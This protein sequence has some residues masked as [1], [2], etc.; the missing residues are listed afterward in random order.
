MIDLVRISEMPRAPPAPLFPGACCA[1][2]S[3][4]QYKLKDG[5]EREI[6][7]Q[8]GVI[9]KVL[10]TPRADEMAWASGAGRAQVLGVLPGQIW[11]SASPSSRVDRLRASLKKAAPNAKPAEIDVI[12]QLTVMDPNRRASAATALKL[13]YFAG[14]PAKQKPVVTKVESAAHIGERFAFERQREVHTS[15]DAL[16]R[17]VAGDVEKLSS[18]VPAA[19]DAGEAA[20]GD[21][22]LPPPAA[23]G[24]VVASLKEGPAAHPQQPKE[25]QSGHSPP[26]PKHGKTGHGKSGV[27]SGGGGGGP[28]AFG[29]T[30]AVLRAMEC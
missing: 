14:L 11:S 6:D 8:L 18:S 27:K 1:P 7:D 9:V 12:R 30:T 5:G 15:L 23:P 25:K 21:E 22:A 4:K 20:A 3:L 13:E 26:R 29:N 10:G 2:W 19:L 17:L 28:A 16:K 24:A